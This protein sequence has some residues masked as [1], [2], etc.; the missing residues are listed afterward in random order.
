MIR[1][2]LRY[3][4]LWKNRKDRETQIKILLYIVNIFT[5]TVG[6]I[7]GL[8]FFQVSKPMFIINCYFLILNCYSYYLL[9]MDNKEE[10]TNLTLMELW[11]FLICA[12]LFIGWGYGF[13][14]Y[15]FCI[16]CVF[17]LPFYLPENQKKKR[18]HKVGTGLL[19]IITYL[20]L[21]YLCNFTNLNIGIGGSVYK[22]K[23]VYVV[24]FLITA[25]GIMTFSVFSTAVNF[26][27]RKKLTRRADYDQLTKLYNRY[28]VNQVLNNLVKSKQDFYIAIADIDYFKKINDTYG[29][30]VGDETLKKVAHVFTKQSKDMYQ[31]GRWGG[32][33]FIFI[34]PATIEYEQFLNKLDDIRKYFKDSKFKFLGNTVKFTISIGVSKYDKR[35]KIQNIIKLADDNLYKAKE[36]GRNKIIG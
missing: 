11:L 24:N 20:I 4:M 7:F 18:Y 22:M 8:F 29:H 23:I 1:P 21:Y 15:I 3:K 13:Q 6:F 33:E 14:Q 30:N 2:V 26:D 31:V 34:A 9:E 36:S 12:V 5:F 35:Q 27:D 19:L 25:I 32:E 28:A 17:F 16:L 10:F